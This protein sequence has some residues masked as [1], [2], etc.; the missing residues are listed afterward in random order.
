MN[1]HPFSLYIDIFAGKSDFEKITDMLAQYNN[2][3][4]PVFRLLDEWHAPV[5]KYDLLIIDAGHLPI[6]SDKII[7]YASSYEAVIVINT[8]LQS[9]Y[10]TYLFDHGI[11]YWLKEG[12]LALDWL[13]FFKNFITRTQLEFERNILDKLIHSAQNSVVI[14]DTK[15]NIQYANPYFEKVSGYTT[16]EFIKKTPN[17]IKSGNHEDSFYADLWETINSKNVW[18]GIFINKSKDGPLFYEEATISPILN[19]HGELDR[20]LKIGKNI[21]RERLLLDELSA[22]VKLARQVVDALLPKKHKDRRIHLDFELR[23]HN[24]IGGDF[25]FFQ[26]SSD[27]RYNF[28]IIDVM[29]HGVSAA[30]I[31]IT[32]MQMFADYIQF[33]SLETSVNAVNRFLCLFNNGQEDRGH[34]ITGTFATFDFKA[35]TGKLINAGHNDT[36][37]VLKEGSVE[38]INSNNMI[39]GVVY[40]FEY[41][42]YTFSLKKY[43]HLFFFTDGL[44][45][46][47]GLDYDEAL[48]QMENLLE[49]SSPQKCIHSIL[50]HFEPEGDDVTLACITLV[51]TS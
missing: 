4:T 11:T 27:F 47:Q 1:F 37:A 14:T 38:K 29:G 41:E 46:K 30:L 22:E 8:P 16:R 25:V 34:F 19:H 13:V 6:G 50:D 36:L 9:A 35:Q 49:L 43:S 51:G 10:Y 15:G 3:S 12:Y 31:A 5:C 33:N 28:A 21:T 23:H 40:G 18:E 45:E 48:M 44:Y 24:E 26:K 7:T 39:L 20:F 2:I 32:V 42:L 17:V